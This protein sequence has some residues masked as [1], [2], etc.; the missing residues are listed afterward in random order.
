MSSFTET[1]IHWVEMT[2]VHK[3]GYI[4]VFPQLR[5]VTETTHQYFKAQG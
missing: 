1:L 5:V 3:H 4:A 2:H